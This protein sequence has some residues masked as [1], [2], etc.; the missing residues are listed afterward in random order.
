[1]RI[2]IFCF[3]FFVPFIAASMAPKANAHR[4]VSEHIQHRVRFQKDDPPGP[5]APELRKDQESVKATGYEFLASTGANGARPVGLL[6]A[7][8][9][10]SQRS[11]DDREWRQLDPAP[12]LGI[13]VH[14]S[15]IFRG[16]WKTSLVGRGMDA[17]ISR[18]LHATKENSFYLDIDGA[19][20]TRQS[21]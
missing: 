3:L 21:G 18:F 9:P 5:R 6:S 14:S 11:F 1:M 8:V 4:C 15:K 10:Y 20:P 2:I 19:M 16:D 7:N 17:N 12:R 13:E